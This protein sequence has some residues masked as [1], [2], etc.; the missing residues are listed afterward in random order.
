FIVLMLMPRLPS[1]EETSPSRPGRLFMISYSMYCSI[2]LSG[3]IPFFSS[4]SL[5]MYTSPLCY[6]YFHHL[7]MTP[8][9]QADTG[10]HGRLPPCSQNG[11]AAVLQGGKPCPLPTAARSSPLP[12]HRELCRSP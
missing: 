11:I 3:Y 10:P 2:F 7:L 4:A 8:S 12:L 9:D 6:S 5:F 1:S